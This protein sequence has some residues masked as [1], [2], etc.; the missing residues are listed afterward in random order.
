M[1]IG[2]IEAAC[3]R[4]DVSGL[5]DAFKIVELEVD[6]SLLLAS[7]YYEN[8]SQ[9]RSINNPALGEKHSHLWHGTDLSDYSRAEK[10]A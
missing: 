10:R 3:M 4:R 8:I 2:Q 5:E 7:S 6:R 9:L 1:L